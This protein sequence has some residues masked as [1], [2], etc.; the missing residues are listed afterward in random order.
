MSKN[1]G[2]IRK[3]MGEIKMADSNRQNT[4]SIIEI[5]RQIDVGNVVLPD[6]QRDF[7]WDESKTYDLFDSL[8][9]DIFIGSIIVV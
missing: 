4:E 1:M 2:Y 7:V 5:I 3:D 9:K 8:I 6:F